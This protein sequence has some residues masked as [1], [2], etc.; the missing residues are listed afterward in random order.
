MKKNITFLLLTLIFYL[1]LSSCKNTNDN[2]KLKIGL[3]PA[4]DT[5]PFFYAQEQG[6]FTKA[7]IDVEL[8]IFTDAGNRQTALQT[9]SIDGAMTDMVALI[10]NVAAGFPIKGTL[11]TNGSFPLLINPNFD[12]QTNPK[13]GMMEVSVSN[14]LVSEYMKDQGYSKVFINAIPMRLEA[15]AAGHIDMGL[16]PEPLASIGQMKGLIKKSYPGIPKESLDILVF[17]NQSLKDKKSSIKVFHSVYAQAVLALQENPNLAREVLIR[18]IPNLPPTVKDSIE[19]PIYTNP[20][21]P[22]SEFTKKIM[23]WTAEISKHK[24][25]LTDKDLFDTSFIK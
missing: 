20:T 18:S 23:T 19:L 9:N 3:M 4:V 5:A 6:L 12:Y 11:S 7:G 25:E 17:T 10:S 15:V 16:F 2:G 21:V 14:Y 24:I 1:V 22:S 13:I 8:T